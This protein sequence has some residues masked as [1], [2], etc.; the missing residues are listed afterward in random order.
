MTEPWRR[1]FYKWSNDEGT[2]PDLVAFAAGWNAHEALSHAEFDAHLVPILAA[3]QQASPPA[4]IDVERLY[5]A[6]TAIDER[7]AEFT[8]EPMDDPV[9]RRSYAET[10]AAEY[11]RLAPQPTAD[12]I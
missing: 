7:I 8:E 6:L 2:N 9:G 5:G 1:A 3:I 4:S 11:V 10:V 12:P